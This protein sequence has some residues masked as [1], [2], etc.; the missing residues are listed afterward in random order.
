M[1]STK[2]GKEAYLEP[3]VED[4][5][6]RFIVRMGKPADEQVTKQGTKLARGASFW[7]VMSRVPI[8]A[9]YIYAEANA[10]RMGARLMAVVIAGT[11]GRV[12][13]SPTA[14]D[15][16]IARTANPTFRP[17]VLM[18]DNPRSFSPPLYGLKTFGDIFSPRQIAA[19]STLADLVQEVRELVKRDSS[20]SSLPC[21]ADG[22]A[23]GGRGANA[24]ADAV[25][26]LVAFAVD[27]TVEY[28]T[29]RASASYRTLARE[30]KE[31]VW[32]VSCSYTVPLISKTT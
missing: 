23:C 24:Y 8:G 27:K 12:Y 20:A 13:L 32:L 26:T 3:I 6:Y 4:N 31:Y 22:M 29:N 10:G 25:A 19:L 1:L 18:A 7:C 17:D 30:W 9:E 11:R 15:E 2:A 5:G 21:D 16:V 14:A 28:A